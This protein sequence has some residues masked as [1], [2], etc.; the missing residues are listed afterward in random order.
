MYSLNIT[1]T[2]TKSK[3]SFIIILGALSAFAPLSMDMYLPALPTVAE[4]LHTSTSSA[5]LSITACLL[6]LALGQLFFGPLSDRLGRKK[7]LLSTLSIYAVSSLLCGLTSS[8]E[9]LIV[10]RFIQGFSGAAGIVISRAA[11][12]DLYSGNDLTKFIALLALVNGAAPVL[13]PLFGGVILK[14]AEWHYIFYTLSVVG[15]ILLISVIFKLPET[16]DDTNRNKG[17]LLSIYKPIPTL[18]KNKKF[19]SYVIA[20]ALIMSCLFSY[21]S[22]SPFVLQNMYGLSAQAFSASFAIN[23][24]GIILSTQITA[25]LST[26]LG[27]KKLLKIGVTMATLA[28]V[29][30]LVVALLNA[31]LSMMLI[32]LFLLVVSVGCV[33]TTAFSLAIQDQAEQAGSASAILGL[34][35]FVGGAIVSPLV[36]I[37]GEESAIPMTVIIFSCSSLAL[38]IQL[39]TNRKK[40][41]EE[42]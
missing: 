14:F 28:G 42:Y 35:P 19:M 13:A 36:G 6:G 9:L 16:L 12:R 15:L 31:P 38:I 22:G 10:L 1:A 11:A 4:N 29:L 24:I 39:L 33:T 2:I 40:L 17:S 3:L 26:S 23:G 32:G 18:L 25:R 5:Q 30:L 21:I 20:Q 27:E 41:N 8:I 7:P 37:A 34:L